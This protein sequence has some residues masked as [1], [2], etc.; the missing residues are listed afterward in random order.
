MKKLIYFLII[1]AVG[2]IVYNTFFLDIS[3]L[4]E[5]DS[6]VALIGI[7]A[8]ASAIVLLL[9]LNTAKVIEKKTKN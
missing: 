2:L 8:S 3:N 7:F 1:A 5:G 6:L 9:I 4:T